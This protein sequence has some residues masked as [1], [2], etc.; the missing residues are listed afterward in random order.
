[1]SDITADVTRDDAAEG[2]GVVLRSVGRV[3]LVSYGLVHV[4]VAALAVQVAFGDRERADKKGALAAVAATGPGLVLLWVVTVGLVALVVWQLAE[5]VLG[6]RGSPPRQRALRIAINL[7]EAGLFGVLAWSAGSTAAKGGA[8]STGPSF[9]SV[10]LGWPGGPWLVGIAGAGVVV[11]S[12]YAVRRGV[13]HTFLRELD[14]R[15]VGLRRSTLVTRVGQVGWTALGVAYGVPGVL[16]VIAAVRYDPAAPTTLDAGLQ[17][18]ADEP[19]GP[20]L[21]VLLAL[22]LVAFGVHCLFDARY[23][24]A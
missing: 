9:T 1:M 3:G 2:V 6:H 18:L 23:R 22:G 17:A 24:R 12:A 15:G 19:Y 20:P 4:L 10:V 16:I 21:L 14:L 5:A 11:G 8:P 7:A 13:Q